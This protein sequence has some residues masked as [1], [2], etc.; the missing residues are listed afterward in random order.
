MRQ[1]PEKHKADAPRKLGVYVVT[2]SSS[3]FSQQTVHDAKTDDPSGDLIVKICEDA[4]HFVVG[5]T[6]LPDDRKMIQS[7]VDNALSLKNVDAVTITGGT[8][9]SARDITIESVH[10]FMSKELPGFG[11]LFRRISYEKI[12]ASAMMSRATA[13]VTKEG[14]AIF[15]LPGSPEGVETA[16][17]K[18][19]IPELPHVLKVAR[20]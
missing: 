7:A 19:V 2:C 11:E 6:L 18:L 17:T 13:G 15:C 8:G 1:V 5:R 20:Q 3:R 4:G 9:I 10:K 16:M 14:K 12:G